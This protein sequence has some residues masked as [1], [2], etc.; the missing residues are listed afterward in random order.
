MEWSTHLPGRMQCGNGRSLLPPKSSGKWQRASGMLF[1]HGGWYNSLLEGDLAS[2]VTQSYQKLLPEKL[3]DTECLPTHACST[4]GVLDTAVPNTQRT[5]RRW[6]A[7]STWNTIQ[8]FEKMEQVQAK[9]IIHSPQSHVKW[10]WNKNN[11]LVRFCFCFR[12]YCTGTKSH[13]QMET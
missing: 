12:N 10:L 6:C 7:G 9:N 3:K 13:F 4:S 5:K 11:H 1:I 2:W 8:L